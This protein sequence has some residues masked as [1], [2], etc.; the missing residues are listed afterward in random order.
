MTPQ[1]HQNNQTLLN[2]WK[3]KLAANCPDIWCIFISSLIWVDMKYLSVLWYCSPLWKSMLLLP[4]V[5][6][7]R[8]RACR[9]KFSHANSRI[10]GPPPLL[11]KT[12]PAEG[13]LLAGF[14]FQEWT[15]TRWY[16]YTDADNESCT[17]Y[18]KLSINSY[19]GGGGRGRCSL[20]DIFQVS[21][22][23]NYIFIESCYGE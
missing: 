10:Q 8:A 4:N 6:G 21:F 2:I 17:Y 23:S 3:Q 13:G 22:W 18:E 1:I 12:S 20:T 14:L 16:D 15:W 9:D 7:V 5:A 19:W 11:K